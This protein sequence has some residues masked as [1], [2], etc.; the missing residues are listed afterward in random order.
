MPIRAYLPPN[1]GAFDPIDVHCMSV[2]L[3]DVC[4]ALKLPPEDK[5]AK[6]IIAE[7]IIELARE[8]ELDSSKL[9]EKVLREAGE[10][11]AV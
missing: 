6:R 2:A 4:K 3:E 8:G 11:D 1:G 7:R 9:S 5:A 10:A